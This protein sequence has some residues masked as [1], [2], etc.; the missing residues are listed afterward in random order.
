MV[1]ERLADWRLRGCDIVLAFRAYVLSN[2]A[3]GEPIAD[4]QVI[5]TGTLIWKSAHRFGDKDLVR[6]HLTDTSRWPNWLR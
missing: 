3:I 6:L 1:R 4:V 5:I 2:E